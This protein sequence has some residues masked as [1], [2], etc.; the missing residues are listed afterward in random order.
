MPQCPSKRVTSR[1]LA[2]NAY[3]YLVLA[4]VIIPILVIK[5]AE[6]GL[7]WHNA[8]WGQASSLR[9]VQALQPI[10]GLCVRQPENKQAS[11]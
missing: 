2:L 8:C 4:F 6:A 9:E 5:G 11:R 10:P 3:V 7:R 1:S